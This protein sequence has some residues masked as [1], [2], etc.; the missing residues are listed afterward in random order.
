MSA[1][2][3]LTGHDDTSEILRLAG[4]DAVKSKAIIISGNILRTKGVSQKKLDAAYE[5]YKENSEEFLL[6][7]YRRAS[8]KEQVERAIDLV[9]AL[10]T[11]EIQRAFRVIYDSSGQNRKDYIQPLFDW[12]DSVILAASKASLRL[13]KIKTVEKILKY[14]I[15]LSSF[16]ETD[17]DVTIEEALKIKD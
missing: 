9:E 6:T 10:Y 14:K 8:V 5:E 3:K 11:L 12:I 7:K 13:S 15:D 4:T 17:P 1:K 2:I 16:Q